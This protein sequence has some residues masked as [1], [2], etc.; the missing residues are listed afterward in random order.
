LARI[1]G[2]QSARNCPLS[3]AGQRRKARERGIMKPDARSKSGWASSRL[4]VTLGVCVSAALI[5][6]FGFCLLLVIA[7]T[8]Q[9]CMNEHWRPGGHS[10]VT[11]AVSH[12]GDAVVFNAHGEG[13]RDLY[14]LDL[15]T[16]SITRIFLES[17]PDGPSGNSKENLW[18]AF[19][20]GGDPREIANYRL[21]DE[22]LNWR[23]DKPAPSK[24]P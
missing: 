9:G 22:P 16:H 11:F 13:G 2:A 24:A 8:L 3:H 17:W 20:D 19:V 15:A 18:E 4:L 14:V 10:D 21:F 23:P 5:L 12:R 1:T 6:S 7:A